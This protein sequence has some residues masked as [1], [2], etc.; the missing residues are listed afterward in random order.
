MAERTFTD[1]FAQGEVRIVKWVGLKTGDTG[2][3]LLIPY[4]AD[5][6]VEVYG[7]WGATGIALIQGSNDLYTDVSKT[8]FTAHKSD[9]TPLSFTANDGFFISDNPYLIRPS[10][11]GDANTDLTVIICLK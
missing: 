9:L 7:T 11:T 8:Y 6:T 4:R 1:R 2:A 3:P 10:V 5:K